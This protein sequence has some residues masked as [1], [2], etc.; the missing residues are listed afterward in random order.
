MISLINVFALGVAASR[1]AVTNSAMPLPV[2]LDVVKM[3]MR[4]GMF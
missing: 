4:G 1:I 3:R 2:S